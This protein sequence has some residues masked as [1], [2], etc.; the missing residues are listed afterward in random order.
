MAL[1][2][3]N[4]QKSQNSSVFNKKTLYS[5]AQVLSPVLRGTPDHETGTRRVAPAAPRRVG[6]EKSF[7]CVLDPELAIALPLEATR[8]KAYFPRSPINRNFL[9][10]AVP[11]TPG[12]ER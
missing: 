2:N 4:T 8:Y 11:T 5:Y 3:I 10:K 6:E 12:A 1:V 9:T 7:Y